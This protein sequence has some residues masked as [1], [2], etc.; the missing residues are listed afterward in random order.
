MLV[1]LAYKVS[2]KTQTVANSPVTVI[3]TITSAPGF[4]CFLFLFFFLVVLVL[5]NLLKFHLPILSQIYE[6][7][8]TRKSNLA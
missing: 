6:H 7:Y 3:L 8:I 2:N 1:L 5:K 4:F